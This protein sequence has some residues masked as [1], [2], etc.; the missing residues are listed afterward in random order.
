MRRERQ[1]ITQLRALLLQR[2]QAFHLLV[3]VDQQI[4]ALVP[5]ADVAPLAQLGL[6]TQAE[7]DELASIHGDDNAAAAESRVNGYAGRPRKS[8]AKGN[9]L[10]GHPLDE[11]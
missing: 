1:R 3:Q 5:Q 7:G 6:I 10:T 9:V 4:Q 2:S 11:E 8:R